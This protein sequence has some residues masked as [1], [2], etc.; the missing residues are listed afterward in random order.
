MARRRQ[1]KAGQEWVRLL[2]RPNQAP[3]EHWLHYTLPDGTKPY[4]PA[5]VSTDKWELHAAATVEALKAD[6]KLSAFLEFA[7]TPPEEIE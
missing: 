7:T 5:R 1:A 3:G 2:H 4:Q 6:P